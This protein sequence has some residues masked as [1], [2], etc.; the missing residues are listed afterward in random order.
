ML[1][2]L[3]NFFTRKAAPVD[4][5]TQ[6]TRRSTFDQALRTYPAHVPPHRGL[7]PDITAEQAQANWDWFK[8]TLPTRLATLRDLCART[9][10]TLSETPVNS[11]DEA[12]DLTARLIEWTRACW[13]DKPYLSEHKDRHY[14]AMS[15]R[16]G[17][18]AIFSVV[19]DVATLLGQIIMDGRKEWRWG[20]DMARS[21]L[22][23]QPSLT[24]RRVMLMSPLLGQQR[25]ALLKDMEALVLSRY[26]TPNDFSFRDP[27]EFDSWVEYVRDGYTGREFDFYQGA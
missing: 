2:Q 17:D 23:H 6:T 14:W 13:P 21:S 7:G 20:L 9:G 12:I 3:K 8:L 10:L 1:E 4:S 15:A 5:S 22:G 24:A 25:H 18:D 27:L 11:V 16:T 19:L 26:L